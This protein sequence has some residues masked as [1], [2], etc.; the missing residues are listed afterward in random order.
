MFDGAPQTHA[1]LATRL[2]ADTYWQLI[3][4]LRL[5]LPPP[6]SDSPE[7]LLRRDHAAIARIAALCPGNAVEA[8]LAA[9]FVAASEQW[10]ECLRLAQQPGTNPEW[11]A[12]CRA[13]AIAM[14]RQ[15]QS[16]LRLLLR[17]QQAR[18]KRDADAA[19]AN[20]GA[21]AEHCAISLMADALAAPPQN[22]PA[23]EPALAEPAAPPAPATQPPP[24]PAP[25]TATP[26]PAAPGRV[27]PAE[28]DTAP[29]PPEAALNGFPTAP[30]GAADV[31]VAS[32]PDTNATVD[33]FGCRMN[34]PA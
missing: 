31:R 13:Q 33:R 29:G 17:L 15:A 1:D 34:V 2:P 12:K 20:S 10:K 19:A 7:D 27:A 24:A 9:Q 11:A 22:R 8:D 30:D 4:T 28:R 25:V 26:D 6:L 32:T 18:G 16:A 23:V 21:W 14:M 3:H 5:A